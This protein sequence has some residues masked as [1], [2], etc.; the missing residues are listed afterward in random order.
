MGEGIVKNLYQNRCPN[1]LLPSIPPK[2]NPLCVHHAATRCV[3]KLVP[4]PEINSRAE[5]CD[6]Y[7]RNEYKVGIVQVSYYP[8]RSEKGPRSHNIQ[9][10]WCRDYNPAEQNRCFAQPPDNN[11]PALLE[12]VA[13][14]ISIF[15]IVDAVSKALGT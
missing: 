7:H 6:Q 2:Y 1:S 4:L 15:P 12:D 8:Q 9:Y 5:V 13:S 14:E 10:Q 11:Y 3:E